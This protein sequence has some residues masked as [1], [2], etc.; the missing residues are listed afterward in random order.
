MRVGVEQ[1][2]AAFW[3][4]TAGNRAKESELLGKELKEARAEAAYYRLQFRAY[5][6]WGWWW[7]SAAIV[8]AV[9]LA[10]AL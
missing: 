7:F 9:A 6:I 1:E 3:Q 10:F 8:L 5:R 2:V 4:D